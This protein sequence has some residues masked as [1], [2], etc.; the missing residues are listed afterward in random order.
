VIH[1]PGHSD[2]SMCLHV[3]DSLFTGDTLL[4]GQAGRADLP[5][6]DAGEE[7]DSIYGKILALPDRTK[8]YPG[9]DYED[10]LYVVLG[11]ERRTNPF[12]QQENRGAYIAFVRDFFPPISESLHGGE[13]SLQCGTRRVASPNEQFKAISANRLKKMLDTDPPAMMIDVRESSEIDAIP[14]IPGAVNI[15]IRELQQRTDKLPADKNAR[16][17]TI[18]HMGGRSFEAA[19]FLASRLGYTNVKNLDGG[20]IAWL[21]VMAMG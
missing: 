21:Q 3:E 16:I 20:I 4:V 12:L 19:H 18:C 8:I 6:G 1:T 2:N 11:E 14:M 10:N 9:H 15:S 5:S 7:Y 13:M 17:I